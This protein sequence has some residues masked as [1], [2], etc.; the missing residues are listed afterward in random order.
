M[1]RELKHVFGDTGLVTVDL[2]SFDKQT[3]PLV[4]NEIITRSGF[5]L[6]EGAIEHGYSKRAAGSA[7]PCPRCGAAAKRRIANF[8]YATNIAPRAML[9]PA[10]YFCTACPESM[11][12]RKMR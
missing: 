10:G 3:G 5:Q 8:I 12:R 9:P 7:D 4:W 6:F 1:K 2:D 11:L